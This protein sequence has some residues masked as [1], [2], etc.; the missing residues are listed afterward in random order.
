MTEQLGWKIFK[1]PRASEITIKLPGFCVFIT[2]VTKVPAKYCQ[3]V[4][5]NPWKKLLI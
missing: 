1:K 2:S 5:M 4:L 3:F